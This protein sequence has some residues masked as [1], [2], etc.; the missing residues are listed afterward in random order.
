VRGYDLDRCY[1]YTDSITDLPMLS[2]VGHAVAV[3]PDRELRA[4]AVA[5]GWEVRD[6]HAPVRLRDR[7]PEPR[8]A[9]QALGGV[10]A[11]A[12]VGLLVWRYVTRD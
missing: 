1:A 11:A 5:M 9:G 10:L 6:F 3:N 2:T 8:T 12:T 7:L 4:A